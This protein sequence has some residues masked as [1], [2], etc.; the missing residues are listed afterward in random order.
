M[1]NIRRVVLT[2]MAVAIASAGLVTSPASAANGE[3]SFVSK[4]NAERSARGLAPLEVYWDLVDDAR[5]HSATMASEDRL[6]HN[7]NL[8]GVT[9]G[10]QGLGENV[11]VGP[12]VSSLHDAF[13]ASSGHR[14]NILGD[15]NYVGVGVVKESDTKIW[16]TVVFMRGPAGLVTPAEEPPAEEPP[17]EES[18]AEESPAE[19]PPT[20]GEATTRRASE[21]VGGAPPDTAVAAEPPADHARTPARY[22]GRHGRFGPY[23]V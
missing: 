16:V 23:I 6:H 17:A 21:P 13:M 4:M 5:A 7:P 8:G 20:D 12:S 15:F 1:G 19:A 3:G 22:G 11:G 10:W 14:A 9:S 2:V 18:P